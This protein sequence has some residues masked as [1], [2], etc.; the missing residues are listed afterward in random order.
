MFYVKNVIAQE[1]VQD[2]ILSNEEL[3]GTIL[4]AATPVITA[5]NSVIVKENL[6]QFIEENDLLATYESI[7]QFSED[8]IVVFVEGI[9]SILSDSSL[10]QEAKIEAIDYALSDEDEEWLL[11]A[12]DDSKLKRGAKFAGKTAA[13][14]AAGAAAG[15]GAAKGAA[16]LKAAGAKGVA[17]K[18]LG[19]KTAGAVGT[20]MAAAKGGATALGKGAAGL[21]G[22]SALGAKAVGIAKGAGLTAATGGAGLAAAGLA[23]GGYGAYKGAKALHKAYKNRKAAKENK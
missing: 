15:V 23:A 7:V 2:L 22:K 12:E 10:S 4:E 11:E 14:G 5:V 3:V 20:K 21:A 6:S 1:S 8:D 9:S 19:A 18:Y 16:A 17:T 13:A